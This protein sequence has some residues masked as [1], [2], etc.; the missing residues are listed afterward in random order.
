MLKKPLLK[1]Y[2]LSIFETLQERLPFSKQASSYYHNLQL[3]YQGE[4]EWESLLQQQL[5]GYVIVL[6]DMRFEVGT[7]TFQVDSLLLTGDSLLLFDVKNFPG[8]YKYEERRWYKLPNKEINNPLLQLMKNETLMRQLLQQLDVNLP[9]ESYDV[10][11]NP[12]FTLYQ[13]PVSK[14]FIFP[15]QLDRFITSMNNRAPITKFH[16]DLAAQLMSLDIGA[17]PHPNIPTYE[18][19][20]LKKGLRCGECCK[21]SMEVV[22]RKSICRKCG[23]SEP[24]ADALLR[25]IKEFRLLFPKEKLTTN[26]VYDWCGEG[27]SQKSIK[28]LLEANFKRVGTNKWVYYV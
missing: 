12:A 25:N 23:K 5:N 14:H 13:A 7:S 10:F 17:Y 21:L 20:Q 18:F 22:G 3:G 9:I 19:T 8:D 16:H 11:I 28:R 1:T 24:N 2:E 6:S 4:K 15:T 26:V 27:Y